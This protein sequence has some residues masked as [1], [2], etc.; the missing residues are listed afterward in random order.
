MAPTANFGSFVSLLETV[1]AN[2]LI[3]VNYG[4]NSAGTG[5]AVPEEAASWVAY[6]NALP[7]NTA[8][9]GVDATGHDWGTAASWAALRA[10]APLAVDD[11]KNFLRISH[12]N[13][14][15]IKYWEVGNELYGNGYYHGSATFAGWE[16]DLHAPYNGTNGT[17]RR[18]NPALSPATYGMGVRAFSTAMKAVDP[19]VQIGGIVN[20]P[21]STY[22]TPT[23]FNSSALGQGC[24][25]MDFAVAHWYPGANIPDLLT[26]PRTGI[27]SMYA[28]LRAV[29]TAGCPAGK[30]ATLPIAIT[31]WGP[32]IN[33]IGNGIYNALI[34]SKPPTQTQIVGLFAA[35]SYANFMEQGVILADWA[36]LHDASYLGQLSTDSGWGYH[37]AVMAHFFAGGG[38]NILPPP[39]V[40][41]AG[42]LMTLLNA[43]ASQHA[44]GTVSVMLTNTSPTIAAAVTVNVSGGSATALNCSGFRY[45]YTSAGGTLDG[46][47]TTEPIFSE[48]TRAAFTVAVPAYSVVVVA[49]PKG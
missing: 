49:F 24:V 25:G 14:V 47:I 29:L 22:Q 5:P 30:G 17:A 21:D 31:E 16:A 10:A 37:G 19:T 44:D 35:E 46:P 27:P 3:T 4:M 8:V 12:P 41:N 20:F 11:G 28:G 6:A 42:A 39:V 38:D 33:T 15:G 45:G 32:N 43:H 18:A 9:I 26:A 40:S 2:A 7:T 13:P 36:Q 48:T 34:A 23:P 1:G